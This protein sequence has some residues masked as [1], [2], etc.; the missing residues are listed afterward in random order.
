MVKGSDEIEQPNAVLHCLIVVNKLT[1]PLV[2]RCLCLVAAATS[3]WMTFSHFQPRIWSMLSGRNW[4][5]MGR[6]GA[7]IQE[8]SWQRKQASKRFNS[9]FNQGITDSSDT[10][11]SSGIVLLL[12]LQNTGNAFCLMRMWLGYASMITFWILPLQAVWPIGSI[13]PASQLQ[14]CRCENGMH[15]L[16]GCSRICIVGGYISETLEGGRMGD[17]LELFGC[18]LCVFLVFWVFHYYIIH[19]HTWR[20]VLRVHDV[21]INHWNIDFWET[22]SGSNRT[23]CMAIM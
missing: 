13:Q 9:G 3:L 12:S 6:R 23:R 1:A 17:N 14:I 18:V 19:I 4:M 21:G 20:T 7:Q 16:D 15:W 2:P 5:M 11:K 8:D 10:L 22:H